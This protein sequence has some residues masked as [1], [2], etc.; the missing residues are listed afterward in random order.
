ML[1][2]GVNEFITRLGGLRER[3]ADAGGVLTLSMKELKDS[4]GAGRL[5]KQVRAR[6]VEGLHYYQ[7]FFTGELP[8]DERADLRIYLRGTKVGRILD[9]AGTLG[10]AADQQL[11]DF[12][13]GDTKSEVDK[14]AGEIRDVLSRYSTG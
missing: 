4:F 13:Y 8:N 2:E 7:L 6:I 5:G 12:A 14:L 10:V 1:E 11:R 3:V 9:A